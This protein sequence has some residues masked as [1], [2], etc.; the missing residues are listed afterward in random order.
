M[1]FIPST[2]YGPHYETEGK[3]LHF[4][5]DLIRKIIRGKKYN[6]SVVL[7]GDGYQK[8]ELIYVGDVVDI[9]ANLPQKYDNENI[10][11]GAGEEFTIRHFADIICEKV[12]YDSS[13]IKYDTE[14]YVGARSKCINV[15]KIK[16][17][18]D[19]KLTP[20]NEGLGKTIEW[21][22]KKI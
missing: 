9:M 8:R 18:M 10:N 19:Y 2:L 3:Q 13:K 20:I 7:W 14:R 22:E 4:I 15:D 11:I 21:F 5:F 16:K 1:Q 12:G 6:E 17:M